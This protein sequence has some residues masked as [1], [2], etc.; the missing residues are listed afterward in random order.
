MYT[1]YSWYTKYT[2]NKRDVFMEKARSIPVFMQ[3]V[4]QI[5]Q[6][7]K[8]DEF[9]SGMMLPKEIDFAKEF[10]VT[11]STLRNALDVL[12]REGF[13]ERRRSKGTVIAPK[14]RYNKHLHADLAI[15]TRLDL[16]DPKNYID[17]LEGRAE[18]GAVIAAATK[19]GM[20][21][22]FVP[23]C[24][25]AHFFDLDEILFRKGIDGF[26]FSSPL[27]L[28]DFVD[29]VVE[30]KIPHVLQESHYDKRGV[31]TIMSDDSAATREC[32]KKLYE[33]GHRK[34]GFY[35]GPLKKSELKSSPRR[36][37]NSFLKACK[38]FGISLQDNWVQT[39]GEDDWENI[40]IDK[41]QAAY[42]MLTAQSRPTAIVTAA[43]RNAM[44]VTKICGKFNI[45][46]PNDLSLTCVGCNDS[47][48]NVVE[49]TGFTKDYEKL[50]E[51]TLDFLMQWIADPLYKPQRK[52]IMP[53]FIELGTIAPINIKKSRNKVEVARQLE[54]V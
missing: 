4:E 29:R 13:I 44:T 16:T 19:R 46:I 37:F 21:I 39:F 52:M 9:V 18:L 8:S 53:D 48:L 31:N 54:F 38:E 24:S 3:I 1:K 40:R 41:T 22:R 30:E 51:L 7:I 10:G 49:C 17:L 50:G 2:K 23:W 28:T 34:I 35:G 33:L 36:C 45:S 14:A 6:R 47:E 12:E 27:Y 5:K 20:L 15:V 25:N 32:V 11:R 43:I 26:I 42:S